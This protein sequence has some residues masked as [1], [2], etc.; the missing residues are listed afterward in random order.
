MIQKTKTQQ[1]LYSFGWWQVQ[2]PGKDVISKQNSKNVQGLDLG[3][4]IKRKW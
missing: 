4:Y 1:T 2:E 3:R